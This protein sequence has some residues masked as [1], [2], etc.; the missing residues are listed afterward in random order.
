MN[1][2]IKLTTLIAFL[3]N[4]GANAC[5]TSEVTYYFDS[6]LAADPAA[7]PTSAG[8]ESTGNGTVTVKKDGTVTMDIMWMIVGDDGP[9]NEENALI[10]IHI[11]LG[12]QY[13]NGPIVFGFCGQSPLPSFGGCQQGWSS[14]S[15]QI[16]TKY[17]GEICNMDDP[18]CV[19]NGQIT[20]SEAAQ[21][22]IDGQVEMYVNIHT[23]KSFEA[24]GNAGPLGL[25]RGQLYLKEESSPVGSDE[26]E[27]GVTSTSRGMKSALRG[28]Y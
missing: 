23:T 8:S 24:N 18:A 28:G 5:G 17:A 15:A 27:P 22:L 9:I 14:D 10:G 6:S 19:N 4:T 26:L 21:M 20:A 7:V 16:A 25:I 11:H 1:L 13:T 12:D 2:F 3:A